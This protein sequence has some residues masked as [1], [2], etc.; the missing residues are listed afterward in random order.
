MGFRDLC[1]IALVFYVLSSK[2]LGVPSAYI[3]G[4][5]YLVAGPIFF[6]QLVF[7]IEWL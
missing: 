7:P 5:V 1:L 3:Y 6:L 2:D 4:F